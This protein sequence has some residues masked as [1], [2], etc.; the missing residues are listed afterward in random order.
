MKILT[1]KT[2]DRIMI[3]KISKI[4]MYFDE[5]WMKRVVWEILTVVKIHD[6]GFMALE[7]IPKASILPQTEG[8]YIGGKTRVFFLK[9]KPVLV[10]Q[11]SRK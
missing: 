8:M 3:D 6:D 7:C 9:I 1:L 11:I 4:D 10:N 2:G 5:S